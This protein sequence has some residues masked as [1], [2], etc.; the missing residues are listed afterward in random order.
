MKFHLFVVW[1][2]YLV[3]VWQCLWHSIRVEDIAFFKN[4]LVDILFLEKH[5]AIFSGIQHFFSVLSGSCSTPEKIE[6]RPRTGPS[7]KTLIKGE[8]KSLELLLL[9]PLTWE[10]YFTY[11]FLK[12]TVETKRADQTCCKRAVD[13]IWLIYCCP[14]SAPKP[15]GYLH[16]LSI[17][18]A[19]PLIANIQNLLSRCVER[20]YNTW[21][22]NL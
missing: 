18:W 16:K 4:C 5:D 3:E 11:R 15:C 19:S 22:P 12:C 2:L 9:I 1:C 17:Q 10:A 14:P 6:S 20:V 8:M 7:A 21:L 13:R